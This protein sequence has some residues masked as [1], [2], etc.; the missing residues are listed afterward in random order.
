MRRRSEIARECVGFK[1]GGRSHCP[2][3]LKVSWTEGRHRRGPVAE[4]RSKSGGAGSRSRTDTLLL[5]DWA[6]A[7]VPVPQ[8][9]DWGLGLHSAPPP[10]ATFPRSSPPP[11][12]ETPA[13]FFRFRKLARGKGAEKAPPHVRYRDALPPTSEPTQAKG[14]KRGAHPSGV[15]WPQKPPSPGPQTSLIPPT[16]R[17][18]GRSRL[19]LKCS[20]FYL[21]FKNKL[22]R[23]KIQNLPFAS[24]NINYVHFR[25]IADNKTCQGQG[26]WGWKERGRFKKGNHFI[27][28]YEGPTL[29]YRIHTT[30]NKV[31]TGFT[32]VR[33]LFF[34]KGE[35]PGGERRRP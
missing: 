20:F 29:L 27:R 16:A 5:V 4:M 31:F 33:D 30:Q 11:S 21:S 3:G 18:T 35:G 12:R 28:C 8:S 6:P 19:Y 26:R 24:C 22:G 14:G 17:V 32:L 9:S 13:G 15:S 23:S 34:K 25:M 7:P 2:L 1:E 10:P